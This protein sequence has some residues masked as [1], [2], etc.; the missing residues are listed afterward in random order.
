MRNLAIGLAFALL[1]AAC[2]GSA[3]RQFRT[4]LVHTSPDNPA[5]DYSLP[6]VLDD[7]TN[8]VIGIE[9][10]E[11]AATDPGPLAVAVDPADPNVIVATWLGGL[12]DADATLAFQ[13]SSPGYTLLLEEREN[14][15]GC[16]AAGIARSLRITLS[17]PVRA[18]DIQPGGG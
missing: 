3:G 18:S 16:P 4:T 2:G 7:Q 9:D 15:G 12:C 17:K 6:V 11:A 8:L 5:G 13:V 1:V 10:S 14:M